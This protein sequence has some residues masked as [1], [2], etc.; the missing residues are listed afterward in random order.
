M[1]AVDSLVYRGAEEE[2]WQADEVK[3]GLECDNGW[4]RGNENPVS[5]FIR[6]VELLDTSGCCHERAVS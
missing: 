6:R 5:N 4:G 1:K 3:K 2:G